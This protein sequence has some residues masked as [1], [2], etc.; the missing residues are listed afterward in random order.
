MIYIKI[1]DFQISQIEDIDTALSMSN[2]CK[3]LHD[4]LTTYYPQFTFDVD[5]NNT[6]SIHFEN[7][8]I[9]IQTYGDIK[10]DILNFQ[11]LILDRQ[12]WTVRKQLDKHAVIM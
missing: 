2:F 6:D 1:S 9:D 8:E 12:T 3:E 5:W 10:Q 4:I 11:V 7:E